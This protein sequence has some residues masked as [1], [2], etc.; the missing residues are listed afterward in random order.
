VAQLWKHKWSV[1]ALVALWFAFEWWISWSAFCEGSHQL[2][3]CIFRGPLSSLV[4][5]MFNWWGNTFH[6]AD[7]YVA[8]FTAVLAFSTI[9][10]W[11]VTKKAADAANLNAE[12]V[13]EAERARIFVQ[14]LGE[15]T[16]LIGKVVSQLT[17]PDSDNITVGTPIKITYRLKNYG[18]TP[19][20]IQEL[21][22]NIIIAPDLP[23]ER[24]YKALVPIPIEQI[25]GAGDSSKDTFC[26][27]ISIIKIKQ[28]KAM[29][30][31]GGTTLW[32]YG[33]ISYD[34][35]FGWNHRLDFVWHY[36]GD[37]LGLRL[38]KFEETHT[39]KNE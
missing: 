38:Y 1:L 4:R 24:E 37:T 11:F 9:L 13:I 30:A 26:Q 23:K 25:I 36:N 6:N 29:H 35:T 21:A 39:K 20:I 33:C 18:K 8:L 22:H 15:N 32:F 3:N 16:G 12:A 7:A 28:A 10:L 17:H 27:Y 34:D 31:I 2:N 5:I 19:A 14:I